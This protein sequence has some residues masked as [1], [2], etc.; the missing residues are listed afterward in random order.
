[1][2]LA[3]GDQRMTSYATVLREPDPRFLVPSGPQGVE[4]DVNA[5][6][7]KKAPAW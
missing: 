5:F 2:G 1:M 4:T 7:L 3:R 6:G